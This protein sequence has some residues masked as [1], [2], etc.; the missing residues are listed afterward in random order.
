MARQIV[1]TSTAAKPSPTDPETS[2]IKGTTIQEQTRE[3]L[4]PVSR[5]SK[6]CLAMVLA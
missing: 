3:C 5:L 1:F 2:Q 4:T 6:T